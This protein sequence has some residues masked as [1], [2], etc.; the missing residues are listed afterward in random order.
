[1]NFRVLGLKNHYQERTSF[2]D[3]SFAH[4]IRMAINLIIL[5]LS[6]SIGIF[7]FSEA[8]AAPTPSKSPDDIILLW[9]GLRINSENAAL[10]V[11]P[12]HEQEIRFSGKASA[13]NIRVLECKSKGWCTAKSGKVTWRAPTD[14]GNYRIS[15]KLQ[16]FSGKAKKALKGEEKKI[17]ITG[18]VGFPGFLLKDGFINGFELG[19]YPDWW[20]MDNPTHYKPPSYFYFLDYD[21]I[22][23]WISEHIRLGDLGYDGRAPIPQ[24]FALDYELVKKL[25]VLTDEL[26]ARGLPSRYHYIG[27]GFISPKSNQL[28]TS[29][30]STAASLSRHL[31]GEAIDFI[32]DENPQDEIMDDMNGDGVIDVRDAFFIRDILT[33]I[34]ESGRCKPGGIGVYS[35]PRNSQI[36]LHVDVRGFS[37]CWGYK[38][39]DAAEF[40]SEKPKRSLRPGG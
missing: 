40:A 20:E 1:M 6:L 16:V 22:G 28:R 11:T 7:G 15:V 39:Y 32:I 26:E 37:T 38:E 17:E 12:G 36:Q 18:L 21:V 3:M 8:G 23:C 19:E 25:E 31:W 9:N 35:P 2:P 14:P 13:L 33:E 24:Y 29:K 30:N 10:L 27:G 34:E 5:L 4:V